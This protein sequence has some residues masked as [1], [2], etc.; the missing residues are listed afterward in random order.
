MG[1]GKTTVSQNLKKKLPDCVFLDGDWC[2]DAD[3]FY[4]TEETKAMVNDNI[5]HILNN[6]IHCSA[7]K[8]IIFCWVMNEQSI[9]D[10]ISERLD[11]ENCEIIP[12]SLMVSEKYLRDR[13][14][15]DI[16]E[17]K[18]NEDIIERSVQR[19]AMYQNMNTIKINTDNKSVDE[20]ID[21]ILAIKNVEE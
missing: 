17:G 14:S 3:P 11:I 12:I 13:L 21:E 16:S 9:M 20:I 8:N 2:W 6:F 10:G 18:R 4:V 7:Y 19:I 15:F 5:C 1:V